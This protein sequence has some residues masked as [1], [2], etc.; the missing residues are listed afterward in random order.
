MMQTKKKDPKPQTNQGTN[1]MSKPKKTKHNNMKKEWAILFKQSIA[2][3]R[4]KKR[5]VNKKRNEKKTE[6][7]ERIKQWQAL[8]CKRNDSEDDF[9]EHVGASINP[10][11]GACETLDHV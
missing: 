2:L 6:E 7:E 8:H 9:N 1:M 3:S 11:P 4:N 5:K 10:P